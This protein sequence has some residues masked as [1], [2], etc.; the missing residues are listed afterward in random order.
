MLPTSRRCYYVVES[1]VLLCYP[2]DTC[3]AA[4]VR[5]YPL[6]G[7]DGCLTRTRTRT[8]IPTRTPTP[9]PTRTP[10]PTLTLTLTFT[11]TPTL[12][13]TLTAGAAVTMD[14][15]D[16]LRFRLELSAPG[17]ATARPALQALQAHAVLV[18]RV[19]SSEPQQA[20][21]TLTELEA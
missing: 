15:S 18:L 5:T 3:A 8:P 4:R 11:L 10:T 2:D 14:A 7:E 16:D 17:A 20:L 19:E 21:L 12:T 6:A 13:P 9:I 1:G